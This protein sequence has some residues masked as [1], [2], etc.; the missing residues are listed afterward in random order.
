M[1]WPYDI[2]TVLD[3]LAVTRMA[4][5]RGQHDG[6]L[7]NWGITWLHNTVTFQSPRPQDEIFQK[8]Q[9]LL[10]SLKRLSTP[11][12]HRIH[13]RKCVLRKHHAISFGKG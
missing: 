1:V 10:S 12:N 8:G 7:C 6:G 2:S 9:S 5:K 13:V 3:S 11:A 4:K